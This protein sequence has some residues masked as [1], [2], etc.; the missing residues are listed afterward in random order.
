MLLVDGIKFSHSDG[1]LVL[2]GFDLRVADGELVGVLGPNGSGKTTLMRLI[3]GVLRPTE[4]QIL[5]RGNNVGGFNSRDRARLISVVPQ[6][7]QLPLNY[8]VLELVLMGRNAHLKLFQKENSRD[9][10]IAF[11]A[12]KLTGTYHLSDRRLGALSGGER[13]RAVVAMTLVQESPLMLLDEPTANLD[14]CH[15][16]GIMALVKQV[17]ADLN[18]TV[19]VAMHDLSLAAQYCNRVVLL[20]AGR[21]YAEGPPKDVLTPDNISNVFGV[22][23]SILSHPN[24]GAPVVLPVTPLD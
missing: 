11:N 3:S 15:Q 19:L 10:E 14:L 9:F 2:N 22:E 12:M 23:V 16:I 1:K 17:Q 20:S 24:G 4:G 13:Q 18:G 8:T 5:F 7:S 21:C 6:A